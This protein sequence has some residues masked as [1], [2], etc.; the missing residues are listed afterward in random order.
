[1]NVDKFHDSIQRDV[2]RTKEMVRRA[3]EVR[4]ASFKMAQAAN[5]EFVEL[6]EKCRH[7]SDSI[8]ANQDYPATIRDVQHICDLCKVCGKI[9]NV[10]PKP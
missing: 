9:L 3:G 7:P 6:Q 1:V 8:N 2:A 5:E 4:E 10:R